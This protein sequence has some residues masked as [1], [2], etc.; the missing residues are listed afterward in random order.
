LAACGNYDPN[1][2]AAYGLPRQG[3]GALKALFP[4][5]TYNKSAATVNMSIAFGIRW[6]EY[7]VALNYGAGDN[8]VNKGINAYNGGGDP[9]Y[10][11]KVDDT[12]KIM[13]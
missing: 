11:K 13:K 12:L 9:N 10:W 8:A 2:G 6:F 5:G 7:K 3:Y 1:E 4:N